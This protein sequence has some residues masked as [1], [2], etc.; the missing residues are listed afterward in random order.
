[1]PKKNKG[2]HNNTRDKKNVRIEKKEME[3]ADKTQYYA[4][5]KNKL[6]KC[7]GRLSFNVTTL[8][9]DI[10]LATAGH[11]LEK[12]SLF[13]EGDCVIISPLSSIN[14]N[15][16]YEILFHY[17]PDQKSILEKEGLLNKVEDPSKKEEIKEL[18]NDDNFSFEIDSR[19]KMADDGDMLIINEMFIDCI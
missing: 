13:R 8:N 17:R 5:I 7:N 4:I 1:M 3:Y 10:R 9:G 6:G 14:M 11:T 15:G 16:K 19:S 12:Q 2:G 18:P